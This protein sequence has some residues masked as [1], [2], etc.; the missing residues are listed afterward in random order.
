MQHETHQLPVTAVAFS[1]QDDILLTGEGNYL[2]AY[3]SGDK[4]LLAKQ[5]TFR[6]QAIHGIILCEDS[7]S[8]GVI[9]G[10]FLTRRFHLDRSGSG[11]SI[12]LGEVFSTDDWIL[13]AALDPG[14]S[15]LALLTAHNALWISIPH[16]DDDNGLHDRLVPGSNCIL[17]SAHI[18]WLS[19]SS[20][21]IAS[22][23]AFGDIIVW[24][25]APTQSSG[26]WSAQSQIHYTFPA[27]A[28]S[29][30]GV[31]I[32]PW[33][34]F[35]S[36]KN[37]KIVLASCSDDRNIKLWD[38]SDLSAASPGLAQVVHETGFSTTPGGSGNASPPLLARTMGH[39]SRIWHVRF[40]ING[41]AT[42]LNSLLSFGEDA[43]SITWSLTAASKPTTLP[44]VLNEDHVVAAHAGKN[45]W[46]VDIT[47]DGAVATGGADGAMALSPS[48][49]PIR[50][51]E[52]PRALLG[53]G[54]DSFKAYGFVGRNA[55]LATTEQGRVA[56]LD[57]SSAESTA[58]TIIA[59]P[60][61]ELRGYSVVECTA[62][63]AFIAGT[64]GNLYSYVHGCRQLYKVTELTGKA[65]G[66]FA[67]HRASG[68][69]ALLVTSVVQHSA[70]LLLLPDISAANE[71]RLPSTQ[72]ALALPAGFTVTSFATVTVKGVSY[73]ILG[74]RNGYIAL[75]SFDGNQ[76]DTVRLVL[77]RESV[78]GKEAVTA[79][80]CVPTDFED[81]HTYTV[82]T[83]RDGT[84][85]IHRLSIACDSVELYLVHQLTLPFGPNIEA[86]YL[87]P[88]GG[89]WVW[90][91]KSKHFTVYDVVAQREIMS[92]DCG[93]AHRNCAF[94]PS[95]GGG[96][97][98]WTKA[99]KV[100]RMTQTALPYEL[101]NSGGHGREIKSVAVTT[102][103]RG[104]QIVA[105]GAEDTN[106]KLWETV[107]ESG[108]KCLHTLRKHNTGIQHLQ[109]STD[110]TYLVSSGG[111]EEFYV[112]K[113]SSGLPYID[114]G[115]IC[116]SKHPR[117]GS[118]DLR[119]MGFDLPESLAGSFEISMAYSDST[120]KCW[121]YMDKSWQLLAS[122][123][124]LTACLMDVKSA[125]GDGTAVL[126]TA[127]DGNIVRWVSSDGQQDRQLQWISRHKIHQNAI[128]A[129]TSINLTDG[130]RLLMTGGDDN[131]IAFSRISEEVKTL[132]I[133]RAH[134]AA[135]TGLAI[136]P[137]DEAKFW[138]VSTGIDQRV[139]LWEV[140]VNIA[141]AGVEGIEV[142]MLQDVFTAVADVS[143]LEVCK[144]EGGALGV[145]VCGVGMYL[146]GV[147][148]E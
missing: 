67:A 148:E 54:G 137:I 145:L 12:T 42:T 124:Y 88:S 90:G 121:R 52:I 84:L 105:T 41:T 61:P 58:S 18:R 143:G 36:S 11:F 7:P 118:S 132:L 82:S 111:F 76:S 122:A 101:L 70:L 81:E 37:K 26:K 62:G 43:S 24:S 15:V 95:E 125:H 68:G 92:V 64:N 102:L 85:A 107:V 2:C 109:W 5:L 29:I 4:K 115:V 50:E 146:W 16:T 44:Y 113:I 116:E 130:S 51:S 34:H 9:W 31:Q 89:L 144:L 75:F 104:R 8:T 35:P 97:F 38:I 119:I 139:K 93:G 112:W 73:S 57:L 106:I 49:E 47:A 10:G 140:K 134:A 14:S 117:S 23:T 96:T 21:L 20:C 19:D 78:H 53:P 66:L 69:F 128:H 77:I 98:I 6:A 28:G 45:I 56:L 3:D 32:S 99:S 91:F 136:V 100:Y 127:T 114:L 46:A 74:A 72:L 22:G 63:L 39:I 33:V 59:E 65:A 123:D 71:E 129:V 25:T 94:Q 13:D 86:I 138:L 133:P 103:D 1:G 135:V 108:F 147:P 110:G 27:H 80:H 126:T 83:G 48:P 141:K 30:F 131:A 55:L 40:G 87:T 79:L 120:L 60:L 17:Y 142:K